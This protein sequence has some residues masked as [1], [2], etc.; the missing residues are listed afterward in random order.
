MF[1][2]LVESTSTGAE[3][4]PRRRIFVA[5]FFFVAI[6]FATAVVA[7]IYAADFDLGNE[8]FDISELLSPIVE[9]KP[10]PEPEPEPVRSERNLNDQQ[11]ASTEITRRV[12]IA[13]TDN[14]SLVPDKVST[15]VNPYASIDPRYLDRVRISTVDSGPGIPATNQGGTER[16][17]SIET[18]ITDEPAAKEP[19]PAPPKVE[20]PK[21]PI[22]GGVMTGR[23]TSLPKPVYSVAARS[24]GA[25]GKVTVQITVDEAGKVI[26]ARALD[27]HPLLRAAAVEAAWKA[28]FDPTLLTGMPVKVTGIISYNFTR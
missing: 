1:D 6:L 18:G 12:L 13:S 11:S 22:S 20:L 23:A 3:L 4:R 8:N 17:S 15:E 16:G 28:K 7:S 25:Q 24:V 2:Q 21:A 27:G 9:N 14:P 19:P 5:S 26:S 10:S